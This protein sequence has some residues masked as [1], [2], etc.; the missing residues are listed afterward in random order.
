MI[1]LSQALQILS[2]QSFELKTETVPLD[3]AFNRV[4]AEDVF[5]DRDYPPFNRSAMDGFAIQSSALGIEN[6]FTVIAK[7]LAGE[8]IILPESIQTYHAVQIMTGASVPE[9]FD[10][11]VKIEDCIV[12]NDILKFNPQGLKKW[13]NIAL[14][15]EDTIANNVV[16]SKNSEINLTKILALS[17]LGKSEVLV[18]KLPQISLLTTGDEVVP[19]SQN[20]SKF[21]IRNSNV[22]TIRSGLKRLGIQ[23]QK[24]VHIGD[25]PEELSQAILDLQKTADII[26]CTGGVSAGVA[27]YMP[28]LLVQNGY[29]KIFHKVAIKPGKPIWFGKNNSTFVFALPG[30][31]LSVLTT[32]KVFVEFFLVHILKKESICKE[33]FLEHDVYKKIPLEEFIMVNVQNS[34]CSKVVTNGSGDVISGI[35]ANA[36]AHFP[37]DLSTISAGSSIKIYEI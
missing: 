11:V 6:Q 21:Q 26:I 15:G 20:P 3:D 29:E 2:A 12:E 14:K 36:L 35:R 23:L 33:V 13:S 17:S 28:N 5:A 16:V 27:D 7:I 9:P 22:H 10:C 31:P 30:N 25:N 8:E 1:Q 18:Y 24:H 34:T 37:A 19:V 32:F 4:L